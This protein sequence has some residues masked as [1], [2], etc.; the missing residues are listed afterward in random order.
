MNR[1]SSVDCHGRWA[2]MEKSGLGHAYLIEAKQ[3][4]GARLEATVDTDGRGGM[5]SKL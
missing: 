4:E 3:N 5:T 1:S 2:M